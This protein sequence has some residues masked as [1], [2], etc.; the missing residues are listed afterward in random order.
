MNE[1]ERL[2]LNIG[3]ISKNIK[4]EEKNI[5]TLMCF[6]SIYLSENFSYNYNSNYLNEEFKNFKKS[7]FDFEKKIDFCSKI[8]KLIKSKNCFLLKLD[9]FKLSIDNYYKFEHFEGEWIESIEK[10][11]IRESMMEKY[12]KVKIEKNY[13]VFSF[14][15]NIDNINESKLNFEKRLDNILKN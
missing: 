7:I 8:S 4:K 10:N 9:L 5:D 6:F 2:K 3:K 13:E 1:F 11:Y 12:L 14:E 15:F